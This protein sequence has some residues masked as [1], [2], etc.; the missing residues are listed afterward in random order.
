MNNKCNKG[1]CGCSRKLE[2]DEAVK[3]HLDKQLVNERELA[4]EMELEKA[5][6][7][8]ASVKE[9]LAASTQRSFFGTQ[10][11]KPCAEVSFTPNSEKSE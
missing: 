7:E 6:A 9:K 2:L 11:F 10:G 5:Q 3:K 8:L 1:S 4:L